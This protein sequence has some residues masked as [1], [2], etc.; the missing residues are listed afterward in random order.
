[1]SFVDGLVGIFGDTLETVSEAS[2]TF[3]EAFAEFGKFF[4]AEKED[5]DDGE[6][7]QMP[8]LKDIHVFSPCSRAQTAAKPAQLLSHRSD[9]LVDTLAGARQMGSERYILVSEGNAA[10]EAV[11]V[12]ERD[13]AIE[14]AW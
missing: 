9:L 3:A 11:G 13:V 12:V 8:R 10:G 7:Q 1:L 4:A 5:H 14:D 2:V 6:D